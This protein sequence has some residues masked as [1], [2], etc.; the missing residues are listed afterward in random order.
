MNID[1]LKEL[2]EVTRRVEGLL[3]QKEQLSLTKVVNFENRQGTRIMSLRR[4]NAEMFI[5]I[6]E[7]TIDAAIRE[8]QEAIEN[9]FGITLE[10]IV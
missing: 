10:D 5:R 3:H 6:A 8:M 7:Q 4:D 1:K 9:K 2:G